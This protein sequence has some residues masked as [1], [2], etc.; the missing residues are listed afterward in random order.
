[1]Q[2]MTHKVVSLGPIDAP[3]WSIRMQ[4]SLQNSTVHAMYSHASTETKRRLVVPLACV[5]VCV[6]L[7]AK[8]FVAD[9]PA[10]GQGGAGR[11]RCRRRAP[12][13]G[14]PVC[15]SV[16]PSDVGWDG[17]STPAGGCADIPPAGAA[18]AR[19]ATGQRLAGG[20]PTGDEAGNEAPLSSEQANTRSAC[21]LLPRRC[22]HR[23]HL[24]QNP[25]RPHG[26][27]HSLLIL[28]RL[29]RATCT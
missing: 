24:H 17:I 27:R 9:G 5:Q 18:I 6:L 25:G 14:L 2:R 12:D 23:G 16:C 19:R 26:R 7:P 1:M 13:L 4:P 28:H 15:S 3:A 29:R 11:T 21:C 8:P 20:L 22:R 10:T